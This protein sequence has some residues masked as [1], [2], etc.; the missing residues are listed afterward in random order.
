MD[1]STPDGLRAGLKRVLDL[2]TL[3]GVAASL[4]QVLSSPTSAATD[5]C[6]IVSRDLALSSRILRLVNSPYYGFA[7]EIASISRAVVVLGFNRIKVLLLTASVIDALRGKG[8]AG[9]R[10]DLF[11]SDSLATAISA[12]S[13]AA[14]VG[15]DRD[16]AFVAGLLHDVGRIALAIHFPGRFQDV[17]DRARAASGRLLQAEG[18]VLGVDHAEVGFWVAEHWGLPEEVAEAI[19]FH[20][21]AVRSRA[22]L[23]AVVALSE[24]VVRGLG[25]GTTGEAHVPPLPAEALDRIGLP[26]SRAGE[27]V[28]SA[29]EGIV[30]GRAFFDLVRGRA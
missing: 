13:C 5:V 22:P 1:S 8:C 24:A 2:P 6:E 23:P 10:A 15:I 4:Q 18:S 16:R 28:A 14:A 21:A 25:I 30:R 20:H 29:V 27:V 26:A 17:L 7:R 19:R 12:E 3:P 11:W 9:I